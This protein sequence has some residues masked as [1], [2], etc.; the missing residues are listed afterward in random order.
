MF[1]SQ[2]SNGLA[3]AIGYMHRYS[4][5][6]MIGVIILGMVFPLWVNTYVLPILPVSVFIIIV[7]TFIQIDFAQIGEGLRSKSPWLNGF[8][9]TFVLAVL[10]FVVTRFMDMPP[11]PRLALLAI[12]AS[13][14]I[15]AAPTI[16]QM[17]G[18][19][20]NTVLLTL[21]SST[22][23]MPLSLYFA[24][25][26][27]MDSP[28]QLDWVS[29]CVRFAIY[30]ILPAIIGY[31]VQK[32]VAPAPLQTARHHCK[33]IAAF[34]AFLF[35]MGIMGNYGLLLR[36]DM[37]WALHLLGYIAVLV[38]IMALSTY[39]VYGFFTDKETT[40]SY[41]TATTT[42][43]SFLAWIVAGPYLGGELLNM[44]G[45][46]QIMMVIGMI[47]VKYSQKSS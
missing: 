18:L 40:L 43:N 25:F 5:E 44:I 47:G 17:L 10:V 37:S 14:P 45:T 23:L 24:I 20:A 26:I 39:W 33:S 35:A 1:K 41:V 9:N 12:V 6:I 16:A 46:T 13:A 29:Y 27:L 7:C 30:L 36:H 28:L 11:E 2:V 31:G 22:L 34:C 4:L 19:Q 21:L 32:Y 42:R 8:W 38:A 3:N 15:L